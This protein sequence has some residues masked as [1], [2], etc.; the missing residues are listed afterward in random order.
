MPSAGGGGA[1][2]EDIGEEEEETRRGRGGE[3]TT[4]STVGMDSLLMHRS[5]RVWRP[6]YTHCLHTIILYIHC[7]I[8]VLHCSLTLY[9]THTHTHTSHTIAHVLHM[10]CTLRTHTSAWSSSSLANPGME[11]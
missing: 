5:S 4:L 11:R 3:G 6:Q 9:T 8:A 7:T 2:E 1:E 10:H